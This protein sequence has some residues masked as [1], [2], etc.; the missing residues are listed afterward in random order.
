[1]INP[2]LLFKKILPKKKKNYTIAFY[3]LENMFDTIDDPDTNDDDFL[4]TAPRRWTIERY[5][6]KLEKLNLTI[7]KI[8]NGA[9]DI[10]PVLIGIAEVENEM[11]VQDLISKKHLGRERYSYVHYDSPDERGIDV[12]LLYKKDYFEVLESRPIAL[13][14]YDDKGNR[15]YTRDILYV[16]GK[17]LGEVVYVLVNH[18]PS[19]RKGA[20]ESKRLKASQLVLD[21]VA[22]IRSEDKRAKIIIMGDFNDG[23]TNESVSQFNYF[24]L[25][26]PML[27]LQM[28][29]QGSLVYYNTKYL[30]DQVIISS[31][32]R[33]KWQRGMVFDSASVYDEEFLKI[34]K[35]KGKGTPFR[36]YHGIKYKG[37]YSDH[38]P[39]Y[40]QIKK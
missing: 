7:S 26:N 31:N 29:H 36:T 37:G 2:L 27:N 1:M 8:G 32:F 13:M 12:A 17:L 28:E 21:T 15:D 22:A 33:K 5:H 6:K 24:N 40:I 23:P 25:Y 14:L 19:R 11:V 4:P 20:N 10:L 9:S 3:N 34:W 35:G 39:V 16:K 18:W 30:F 38:F